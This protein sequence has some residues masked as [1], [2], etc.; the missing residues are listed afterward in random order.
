LAAHSG[1]AAP[2]PT[3]RALRGTD[4]HLGRDQLLDLGVDMADVDQLLRDSP[5]TG[6]GG[7]PFVE[8]DRLR[9]LLEMLQRGSRETDPGRSDA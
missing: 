3:W 2:D 8:A 5:L 1:R 6:H 4:D 7:R 9:D